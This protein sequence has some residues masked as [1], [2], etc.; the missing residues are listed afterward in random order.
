VIAAAPKTTNIYLLDSTGTPIQTISDGAIKTVDLTFTGEYGAAGTLEPAGGAVKFFMK[1][2]NSIVWTYP[3]GG[4]VESVAIQK[5]Y[6]CMEPFPRHDVDVS[7]ISRYTT[8]DGK[9]KFIICQGYT[10]MN[11]SVTLSNHGDYGEWVFVSLYAYSSSNNTIVLIG[12]ALAYVTAGGN[13]TVGMNWT[14]TNVPYYG[15]YTLQATVGAV[16]N[17]NHLAD[18][19]F[20]DSGFNVTGVGDITSN[21]FLVP[22]RVVLVQD[23]SSASSK[24]GSA[25]GQALYNPNCDLNGDG[26]ILVQD[27]SRICSLYG[28]R[29]P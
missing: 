11:I 10:S 1:T 25:T 8:S 19:E 14:T 20:I 7:G 23:V 13:P 18:N 26:K 4:K 28:T 3:V 22:D 24:Y 15:N 27:V 6:Q 12:S 9:V 5:K 16:Q 2:R 21:A 17:E 29:Y